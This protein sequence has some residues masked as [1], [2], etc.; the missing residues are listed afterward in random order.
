MS[1]QNSPKIKRPFIELRDIPYCFILPP[2]ALIAWVTPQRHW[3]AVCTRLVDIFL[4][5]PDYFGKPLLQRVEATLRGLEIKY[6]PREIARSYVTNK[7]LLQFEYYQELRGGKLRSKVEL[8]GRSYLE[9]A[10]GERL[11]A[12]V[13]VT[14]ACSSDFLV[15][16]CFAEQGFALSH[17]S[18][19]T[20]GYSASRFGRRF[21]NGINR[22]VE[23]KYLKDRIVLD[24]NA[25]TNPIRELER[26]VKMN[27]IVSVTA[28]ENKGGRSLRLP[29][30]AG[31]LYLG[32]GAIIT[33]YNTGSPLLPV[34]MRRKANGNYLV[35]IKPPVAVQSDLPREDAI[36][37]ALNAFAKLLEA[38]V[39]EV[40]DQWYGWT[41]MK[42]EDGAPSRKKS[43]WDWINKAA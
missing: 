36:A 29:M 15:K 14:P 10:L 28:V 7:L 43:L 8:T 9:A 17:L 11:G 26:R 6:S 27:E 13:W 2:L 22:Y 37:N 16:K 19:L 12:I 1:S 3:Q 32:A 20:H 5:G 33:A 34:F 25:P 18:D 31:S 23:D 24:R 4:L 30:F 35:E 38:H 21:I 39:L 40:P 42:Y 41:H